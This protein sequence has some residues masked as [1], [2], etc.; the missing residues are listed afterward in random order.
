V[1]TLP[2]LGLD[3]DGPD[4]IAAL[5]VEGGATESGRLLAS[6]SVPALDAARA[7]R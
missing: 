2:G 5:A 1:I 6:F 4:D 7:T 3:I